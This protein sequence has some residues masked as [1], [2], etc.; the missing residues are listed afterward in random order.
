MSPG[1]RGRGGRRVG[2]ALFAGVAFVSLVLSGCGAGGVSASPGGRVEVLTALEPTRWRPVLADEFDGTTLDPAVWATEDIHDWTSYDGEA[3]HAWSLAGNAKVAN[4]A[5][6]L[7][8]RRERFD[9]GSAPTVGWTSAGV[10]TTG[11]ELDLEPSKPDLVRFRYGFVEVRARLAAGRGLMSTVWLLGSETARGGGAWFTEIE[12]VELLGDA[13]RRNHPNYFVPEG[14]DL[15]EP[16][17]CCP[18]AVDYGVDLTAEFHVYGLEWTPTRLR[19]FLDGELVQDVERTASREEQAAVLLME[20]H[21]RAEGPSGRG[22]DAAPDDSTPSVA[23]M[24]VDY[25]RIWQDPTEPA[26]SWHGP[27]GAGELEYQPLVRS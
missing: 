24:E 3:H 17:D 15:S 19:W 27:P 8:A 25:V 4:G 5:L 14:D 10:R 16:P 2:V 11:F 1:L 18:Q 20:L 26:S 6:A 9:P 21:V 23:R 13:P 12:L 22:F 7:E